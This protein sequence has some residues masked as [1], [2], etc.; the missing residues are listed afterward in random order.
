MNIQVIDPTEVPDWDAGLLQTEKIDF[1][2]SSFWARVLKDSYRYKPLY[3]TS[4][5]DGRL[6]LSL[7]LMEVQSV[8]TGKRGVS[9][10]F[11]DQ[12]TPYFLDRQALREAVD[13]CV[14]HGKKAG[15]R[16]VEWRAPDYYEDG[17]PSWEG[18][19]S[20]EIALS[21]N[22]E[23]LFARLRPSNRRNIKK[24]VQEGVSIDV[25]TSWTALTSFCRLNSLTRK[26][27]GLP[28][29]PRRFFEKVFEH[30]LSTGHGLSI[31]ASYGDKVIASSVYFHFGKQALFKYGASDPDFLHLRPNN[32]IMWEAIR[33]CRDRGFGTLSLGRT[34]LDN[35]GLLR[36]KRAW[37]G[38]ERP[39]RYYRYDIK[40]GVF[41][42][43]RPGQAA[44]RKILSR[45]PI[46]TL[47]I[48]GRLAYRHM[49]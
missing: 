5:E 4:S 28:P 27:H 18:Y 10:P 39:I 47:R 13:M 7:P 38:K 21:E 20:H 22:E 49:G 26:R 37:G 40:K 42:M 2:H 23:D 8:W 41:L 3:C 29:Q 11:T 32:L 24:A 33:W 35:P 17:P 46:G 34:E 19:Y 48:M 25:G 31:S 15:W 9:L 30:V 16:Y 1:F 45:M 36:Y 12:C 6:N 14:D 43:K 44:Y